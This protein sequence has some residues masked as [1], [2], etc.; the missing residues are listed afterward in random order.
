MQGAVHKVCGTPA[1]W[2]CN[3]TVNK[4]AHSQIHMQN[5]HLCVHLKLVETILH[6]R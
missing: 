6:C 5:R 3:S 1:K 4:H 2:M